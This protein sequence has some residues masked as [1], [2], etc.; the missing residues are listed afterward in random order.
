M[1]IELFGEISL[2]VFQRTP[3]DKGYP[4][5]LVLKESCL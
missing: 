1:K 5:E 3:A 2:V 4:V